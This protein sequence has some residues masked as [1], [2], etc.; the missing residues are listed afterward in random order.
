MISTKKIIVFFIFAA[1]II[2]GVLIAIYGYKLFKKPIVNLDNESAIFYIPSYYNYDSVK[3]DLKNKELINDVNIFDFLAKKKKYDEN[4]KAGRYEILN[5]M[6]A[7]DLINMLMS[8]RQKA[9]RLTFNNIRFLPKL[10]GIISR[11]IETDSAEF[12]YLMQDETFLDSI[13]YTKETAISIFIPNTYELWWNTDARDFIKRMIVE[14]NKFWNENRK[15]KASKLKLNELEVAILAS[16]VQEETNKKSEMSKIAGVYLNRLKVGMLLQADPT[17]RFAYGDFSVK[18][19]NYDY[20][21]IDSPYNTYK[22]AGLPPGPIC[23][24]EANTIDKVLNPEEHNYYYFCAKA[25][26]SGTHVFSRNL[27]E[28]NNNAKAYHRYLNSLNIRR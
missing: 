11:K 10:A 24:P 4:I 23:M 12:M 19:I 6:T 9:V 20:L 21:A 17:A 2:I 16:I 28:H 8:G 25:D 27:R 14:H 22:Y 26:N 18:R 15:Q 5:G 3:N 1:A 13:G 7:N